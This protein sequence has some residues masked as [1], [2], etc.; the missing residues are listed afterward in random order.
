MT[1]LLFLYM[2]AHT[3]NIS[4]EYQ[5][6]PTYSVGDLI[7]SEIIINSSAVSVNCSLIILRLTGPPSIDIVALSTSKHRAMYLTTCKQFFLGYMSLF[8]Q[9]I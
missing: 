6:T 9:K 4:E 2:A 5:F 1:E 8:K 3:P 7:L